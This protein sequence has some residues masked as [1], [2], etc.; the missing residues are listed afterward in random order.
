M[1]LYRWLLHLYPTSFR[2]EYGADMAAMFERRVSRA[3]FGAR[4]ALWLETIVDIVSNA[5][6]VHLDVLRQDLNYVAR[7]LRRSPG[8]AIAAALI[9]SLGI[10][11]TT[12]AFSI[13]DF[14]LL[15]P[16]PFPDSDRL[17]NLWEVHPGIPEMDF[18]PLNYRD[19]KASVAS[20]EALGAYRGLA[21]N[22]V[23]GSEPRHI[24]GAV[25]SAD[26]FAALRIDP[27]AGRVFVDDDDRETAPATVVLS[28]RLWQTEFGGDSAI[29]GQKIALDGRPYIVVG[30]MPQTF[31]F[32]N[33]DAELWAAMQ[34]RPE[35]F[36]DRN[37][38]YLDTIAR[39]R[40]GVSLDQ[41]RADVA[42]V[43]ERL[44]REYPRENAHT[45]MSVVALR[46]E[47][48]D[49][50][51]VALLA[52]CGAALCVLLI[53]CANLAGLLLAR[54]T[55][56]TRELAVRAALGAGRD[57]LTRQLLTESLLLAG[58]GGLVGVG[59][60]AAAVPL[61]SRLVPAA[62]PVAAPPSIDLRVLVFAFVA[63]AVTGLVFGMAP[64]L[65]TARGGAIH[66]L[67]SASRAGGGAKQRVRSILVIAEIVA[68]VALLVSTGLLLKAMWRVQAIDPGF[69]TEHTLTLRTALPMPKY[70][71][72]AAR[73]RFYA[74][75]LDSIR[76]LPG[77]ASAAYVGFAPMRGGPNFPV[78]INGVAPLDRSLA[79]VASFLT[80]TPGYFATL[81][82]P[83]R[84][85]RDV[86]DTDTR[87]RPF[88]AVVSESFA[89]RFWPDRDPIGRR[90]TFAYADREVVGVVGDAKIRGL[91][92][93][94]EPQVYV[95][96]R[97][98][99]DRFMVWHAPKDLVVRTSGSPTAVAPAIRSIIRKAD[100]Q[101]PISDLE[102]LDELV[103]DQTAA[104]AVQLR[105]LAAFA[106]AAF[107]LAA[108]G[109]H[110]LLSFI[111][112]ERSREIGV[113]I[114][115]G[116]QRTDVFAM[117]ARNGVRLGIAGLTMGVAV[118]YAG[119]R[120]MQ[121]LLAG[122]TPADPSTFGAT[123]GLVAVM[124]VVG[125]LLPT[126]RA[127]RIDPITAIRTE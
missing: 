64:V 62:L 19:L 5:A 12:A 95:P 86:R 101:Q 120:A 54:A 96:Y 127:L 29:L 49:R 31:S 125:M 98:M 6:L 56:R 36:A 25:V 71:T 107:V 52:L 45:G 28:Y 85:G 114:A 39:L 115:L 103:Q 94:N 106:I 46:D 65:R 32:P 88:V 8:F 15:R 11:A 57:R 113:R 105:V 74:A 63:T 121:A 21:V 90:F 81:G 108:V 60:A 123:V 102:T 119:G 61:L 16:L 76:A 3:G 117:V 109:I 53:A 30:I 44:R 23:A 38:N 116:A 9:V 10:G 80:V 27:I 37:D 126:L 84:E 79:D 13:T 122:I 87:D 112:S 14:V 17:V 35:E 70:E 18:S 92:R 4:L 91:E 93:R 75:V 41:A 55:A 124:L 43:A 73:D 20:V 78:G 82:I 48:S 77:V 89:R 66:G 118:A 72:V 58:V 47:V 26:V 51:R 7:T 40:S 100:P 1:T 33:R 2:N 83:I 110:G 97:Q 104:R 22:L 68:S 24:Q 50:S 69:R 59:L 67:V 99:Q 42:L 111:V 34:F